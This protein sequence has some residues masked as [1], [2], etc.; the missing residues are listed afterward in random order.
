[1]YLFECSHGALSKFNPY[2]PHY[3]E[4][5]ASSTILYPQ[6]HRLTLRLAFPLSGETYGLTTFRASTCVG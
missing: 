3:R 5:F 2:P 6:A 1:M 4:A